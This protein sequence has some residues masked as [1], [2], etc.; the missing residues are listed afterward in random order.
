MGTAGLGGKYWRSDGPKKLIAM[1]N[2]SIMGLSGL[3][4]LGRPGAEP[5]WQ[6]WWGRGAVFDRNKGGFKAMA[7]CRKC[8]KNKEHGNNAEDMVAVMARVWMAAEKG[9]RG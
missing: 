4:V 9:V 1:E 5:L 7:K 6:Y 3:V 2:A 8:G